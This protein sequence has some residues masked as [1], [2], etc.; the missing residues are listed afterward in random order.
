MVLRALANLLPV[1]YWRDRG[2]AADCSGTKRHEYK[3]GLLVNAGLS[4][5]D[6]GRHMAVARRGAGNVSQ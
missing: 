2:L 5:A 4:L 3:A 6:M 1:C